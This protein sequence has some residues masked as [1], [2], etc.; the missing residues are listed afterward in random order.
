MYTELSNYA[1]Y[2]ITR[3]PKSTETHQHILNGSRYTIRNITFLWGMKLHHPFQVVW[4]CKLTFGIITPSLWCFFKVTLIFGDNKWIYIYFIN[5]YESIFTY[6]LSNQNNSST[7]HQ[8]YQ[9]NGTVRKRFPRHPLLQWKVFQLGQASGEW[10][11]YKWHH[12]FAFTLQFK[13]R[14]H[15]KMLTVFTLMKFPFFILFCPKSFI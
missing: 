7:K 5:K 3:C 15:S 10:Q 1:V 12:C 9:M 4:G 11:T 6:T 14:Y 8:T 2:T 13:T